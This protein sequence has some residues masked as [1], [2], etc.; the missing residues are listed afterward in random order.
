MRTFE[1]HRDQDL[2]GVSGTGIVVQGVEFDDGR[3]AV[4]W[5]TQVRSTAVYDSLDE[6]LAIHC[7]SGVTRVVYTGD[8]FARGMRDAAQDHCENGPFGSVGGLGARSAM[9]APQWITP[10][11]AA[12]YL[13]G[14]REQARRLYGEDWETCTFGWSKSVT[15]GGPP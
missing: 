9:A 11:E 5:C 4:R 15:I 10:R 7:H 14:Y 2:T 1:L 13:A 8:P 3:V 6:V 12:D